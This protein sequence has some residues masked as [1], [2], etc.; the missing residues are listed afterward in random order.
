MQR[1]RGLP[2]RPSLPPAPHGQQYTTLPNCTHSQYNYNVS[3][4]YA[5]AYMQSNAVASTSYWPQTTPE[6]YTL[7]S[8]YVA[9]TAQPEPASSFQR[10]PSSA[11]YQPGNTRC[12]KPGC[13]FTGSHKSVETHMMD[14]HLIYPPGWDKKRRK[15]DWDADPSLKG[16]PIPIQGTSL[17]LDTPEA[18]EQWISERRKRF[19]T[20]ERVEEKRKKIEEATARGQ[21]SVEEGRFSRDKRRRMDEPH[22][23]RKRGSFHVRSARGRGRGKGLGRSAATRRAPSPQ[24]EISTVNSAD[25]VRDNSAIDTRKNPELEDDIDMRSSDSDSDGPPEVVSSKIAVRLGQGDVTEMKNEVAFETPQTLDV[26][27]KPPKKPLP[28]Q[29]RRPSH[30]PF[31]TRPTLIRNLLLPEIRMTVS[32]LS[33]AIRFLVDNDFL[34][35][36]ELKPG[37]AN[38][39]R[40]E[41]IGEGTET[42]SNHPTESSTYP[43]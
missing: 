5:Q 7:S 16:K 8:T 12:T 37:Q 15:A 14:R 13:T 29:P 6:G 24:V 20:A 2:A 40:I 36:V 26:T 43:V 42:D 31:G 21:L 22:E 30:N 17:K 41:V 25:E 39:R 38:E 3:S 1:G 4:H 23:S 11:W 19:P 28:K 33:Q 27:L 9:S 34:E 18:I 35:N 32:N 10:Q